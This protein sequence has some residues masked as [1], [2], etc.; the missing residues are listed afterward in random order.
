MPLIDKF[1]NYPVDEQALFENNWSGQ[2]L[3]FKQKKI[4]LRK[5]LGDRLELRALAFYS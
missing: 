5:K 2:R 1:Y 4:N 3:V